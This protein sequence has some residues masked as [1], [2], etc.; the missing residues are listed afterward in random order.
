M[1]SFSSV[2]KKELLSELKLKRCC[3]FSLLYG[4]LCFA[5]AEED[6][7]L[8]KKTNAENAHLIQETVNL[9]LKNKSIKYNDKSKEIRLPKEILRFSTFAEYKERVFKCDLCLGS[10]LKAIFLM[11]GTINDP[12]KSY[13]L[14][15]VFD[16]ESLRNSVLN[17]I[18]D[19]GLNA[20]A[21]VRRDKF[22]IYIKS[23]EDIENFLT[24]IGAVN[25]T[26]SVM[27]SKIY[28]EFVNNVNR[29]TNCDN[30][31]IN[32]AIIAS[33]KHIE[34]ILELMEMKKFDSLPEQLKETAL[35]RIEFKE[36]NY[37]QLGKKFT[38]PISKSGIYHRLEKIR[39]IWK[40][41]KSNQN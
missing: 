16:N 27:N 21:S 32:K 31:N 10:F 8:I 25:A 41:L 22:I 34:A 14:E 24:T 7:V 18:L 5:E 2:T 39:S 11:C 1:A 17:L 12:Q 6:Y 35:R 30:A 4:F 3:S 9:I 23:S 36:L 26:F 33:K 13:R 40:G 37:E 29:A 20:K 15:L 28:K 38:P 19:M